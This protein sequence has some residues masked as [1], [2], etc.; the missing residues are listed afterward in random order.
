MGNNIEPT[1]T[2]QS[3]RRMDG[4][5][6]TGLTHK[7]T[8][9]THTYPDINFSGPPFLFFIGYGRD[10]YVP[11]DGYNITVFLCC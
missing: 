11:E 4:Q 1:P 9:E 5:F 8:K 3:T 6:I 7:S 2:S 10:L